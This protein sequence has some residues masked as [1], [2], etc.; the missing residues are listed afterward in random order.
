MLDHFDE[1]LDSFC[2]GCGKDLFIVTVTADQL[3]FAHMPAGLRLLIAGYT[4]GRLE[5]FQIPELL[6][7]SVIIE[8]AV[9]SCTSVTVFFLNEAYAPIRTALPVK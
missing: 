4:D 6:S 8:A 7:D 9:Q 5:T 2:D 3:T 1:T